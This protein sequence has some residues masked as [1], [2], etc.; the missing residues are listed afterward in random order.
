MEL[1]H[2]QSAMHIVSFITR[3]L[4]ETNNSK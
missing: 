4:K 2:Q 1:L 3:V